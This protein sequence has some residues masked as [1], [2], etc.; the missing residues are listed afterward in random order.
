MTY[1]EPL[2]RCSGCGEINAPGIRCDCP[3]GNTPTVPGPGAN[4]PCVHCGVTVS[5]EPHGWQAP[6]HN[7]CAVS[8]DGRHNGGTR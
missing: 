4:R 8:P 6:F 1:V 2:P 5:N 3:A 7:P